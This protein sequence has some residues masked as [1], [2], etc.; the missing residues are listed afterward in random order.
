MSIWSDIKKAA[1]GSKEYQKGKAER[2]AKRAKSPLGKAA[3]QVAKDVK[4]AVKGSK[5]YQAGKAKRKAVKAKKKEGKA[6]TK[7]V[8][9]Q[10]KTGG[11]TMNELIK[12]RNAAKKGSAEYATAQNQINKAYGSKKVHKATKAAPKKAAPKVATQKPRKPIEAQDAADYEAKSKFTEADVARHKENLRK[13]REV[14]DKDSA[15]KAK[16]K[17]KKAIE[18]Y[19]PREDQGPKFAEGGKVESNPYGWPSRDARNGGKG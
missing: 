4:S 19:P 6:W 14:M 17:E 11:K 3:K 9:K 5:E 15:A 8:K 2:K 7:A 1:K 13:H 12:A 10:K 18:P 16:P